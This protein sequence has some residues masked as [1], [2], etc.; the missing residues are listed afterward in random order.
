MKDK[1]MNTFLY[2]GHIELREV[3][4]FVLF[5]FLIFYFFFHF[6]QNRWVFQVKKVLLHSGSLSIVYVLG[7]TVM[8]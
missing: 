5:L 7:D 2:M 4:L 6:R 8:N 1:G 3:I